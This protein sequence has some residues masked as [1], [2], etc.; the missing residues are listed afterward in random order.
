MRNSPCGI[1]VPFRANATI[2]KF[3]ILTGPSAAAATTA[4]GKSYDLARNTSPGAWTTTTEA[5][6]W[7][8]WNAA[9]MAAG[10]GNASSAGVARHR[11][12]IN[13]PTLYQDII[14]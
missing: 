4:A 12:D 7:G 5:I 11:R 3:R 8:P 1:T 6:A 9:G 10:A 13:G 14:P 2:N